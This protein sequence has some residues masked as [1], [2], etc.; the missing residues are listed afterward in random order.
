[1]SQKGGMTH[2]SFS[3]N[4]SHPNPLF[5]L[6]YHIQSTPCSYR[7]VF[8]AEGGRR[9]S[10]F[11]ASN[12]VGRHPSSI[13]MAHSLIQVVAGGTLNEGEAQIPAFKRM[14]ACHHRV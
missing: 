9:D 12:K 5:G 8:L 10:L 14:H 4:D 11:I 13:C 1:M 7:H 3:W 6:I 2:A